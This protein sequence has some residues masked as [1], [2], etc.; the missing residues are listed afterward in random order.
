MNLVDNFEEVTNMF[1][2]GRTV[3]IVAITL[4]KS[5]GLLT[6]AEGTEG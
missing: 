6:G 3:N 2:K 4:G 5:L 1:E